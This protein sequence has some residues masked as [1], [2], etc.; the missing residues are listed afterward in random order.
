MSVLASLNNRRFKN[1]STATV[2]IPAMNIAFQRSTRMSLGQH[3][4][5]KCP[6]IEGQNNPA[7][8]TTINPPPIAVPVQ[9]L[10]LPE[11]IGATSG[12]S[13]HCRAFP[14]SRFSKVPVVTI[15]SPQQ[16]NSQ[17]TAPAASLGSITDTLFF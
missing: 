8:A 3:I 11:L 5:P 1:G 12:R 10:H 13:A 7:I 17:V 2:T 6:A 15:V 9:S 16:P 14:S 4:H